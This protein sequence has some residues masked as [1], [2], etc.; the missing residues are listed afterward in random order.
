MTEAQEKDL[1]K[2]LS[3]VESNVGRLVQA[4]AGISQNIQMAAQLPT[5]CGVCGNN[6]AGMQF[7]AEEYCPQGKDP[8]PE[9]EPE[10]GDQDTT[11]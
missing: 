4:M 6:P 9:G 2:R 3:A 10:D 1:L 8:K 5:Q 7:C 11:V